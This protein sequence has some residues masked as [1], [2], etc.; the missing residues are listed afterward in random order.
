MITYSMAIDNKRER[1]VDN[2]G[3]NKWNW[4]QYNSCSFSRN[5]DRKELLNKMLADIIS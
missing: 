1:Y 3:N 4:E 5:I 2:N